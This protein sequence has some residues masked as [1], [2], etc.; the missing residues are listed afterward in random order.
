[1]R[2]SKKENYRRLRMV[3]TSKLKSGNTITAMDSR[4]VW[5]VRY[6]AGNL[7]WT[8]KELRIMDSKT[9]KI[10]AINRMYHPQSDI[11]PIYIPRKEGSKGILS[12]Q[13]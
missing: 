4:A 6:A 9:L 1:M 13:D 12:I 10:M 11:D 2:K 3:L 5:L 8:K 7:N